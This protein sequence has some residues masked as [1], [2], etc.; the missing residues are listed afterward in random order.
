MVLPRWV[1]DYIRNTAMEDVYVEVRGWMRDVVAPRYRA[2]PSISDVTSPC[3]TKRDVYLRRVLG[4]RMPDSEVLVLGRM[5]HEVFFTV[6][7]N[8]R[9][10]L[11]DMIKDLNDLLSRYGELSRKYGNAIARLYRKVVGLYL[12]SIE[13]GLPISV[14]P[15]VPGAP[16]GLSDFV[17][18][19]LLVGLIPIEVTT[20]RSSNTVDDVDRKEI[21]LA[22]YA[23]ALENWLGHPINFGVVINVR[24]NDEVRLD[25]KVVPIN[26]P[27]RKA[28]LDLRDKVARIIEYSDDPGKA[29]NCPSTCPFYGVCHA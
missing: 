12:Q 28:F 24:L 26:D 7:N 22:G 6:F 4:I 8:R 13:E 11:E 19:D 3:D 29:Q 17:K 27:L 15:T 23:L 25:Y 21:A 10:S 9:D 18:P 2:R 16:I 20:S 5:V 14:E 1:W